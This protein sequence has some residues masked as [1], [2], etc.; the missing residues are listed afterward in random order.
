MKKYFIIIVLTMF[1]VSCENKSDLDISIYQNAKNHL[2]KNLNKYL[3]NT[4]TS[5][6][7]N[8]DELFYMVKND[9]IIKTYKIS[10]NSD[11]L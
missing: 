1:L 10:L 5:Q 7:W 6:I 4:V 3:K 8:D 9:T 11:I 2:S